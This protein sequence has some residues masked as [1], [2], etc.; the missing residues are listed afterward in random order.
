MASYQ[1]SLS[2]LFLLSLFSSSFCSSDINYFQ[3]HILQSSPS[4]SSPF[5]QDFLNTTINYKDNA[6]FA[7]INYGHAFLRGFE[8]TQFA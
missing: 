7:I 2:F 8:T 3:T 5:L 6:T 4:T 1:T